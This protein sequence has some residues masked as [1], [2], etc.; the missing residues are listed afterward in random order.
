MAATV[1]DWN[2]VTPHLRGYYSKIYGAD[3]GGSSGGEGSSPS[4]PDAQ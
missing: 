2:K 1:M 3:G 4:A